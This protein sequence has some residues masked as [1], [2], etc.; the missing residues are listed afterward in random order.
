MMSTILDLAIAVSLADHASSAINSIIGN[1]H[2]MENASRDAQAQME[3]FKT[4]GW[5]GATVG[6]IG[7]AGVVG[8]TKLADKAGEVQMQLIQLGSVYGLN[9]DDSQLKAIEQQAQELSQKTLFSKKQ[10]IGIDLELAHA[11][12]TKEAMQK[13]LPEATYLAEVEVGMGKSSSPEQTA[14]NFARMVDDAG[15]SNKMD[16]MEKFADSI[17]RVINVTHAS[18]ESIGETFKY[19]MPVVKNLG[20]TEQDTL[21]A[22]AMAA[23]SG[24]E[25]SMAGTHIKDF[26]ERI[27]PFKYIGTSGGNRQLEAMAD[28]G[29][30]SGIHGHVNKS[31]KMEITGIDSAALLKD[32]DHLKSYADM[33]DIL[34]KK[35]EEF[36]KKGSTTN[37][38]SQMPAEDLKKMQAYAKAQ[39]GSELTG[40]DLQWAALMNHVFGEQGQDFAVISSHKEMFDRLQ[41]QME[42]QKSLH[43]QIEVIRNSWNGQ[44]HIL[45]SN[46][47]TIGLQIGKPVMELLTPAL[48]M[49]ANAVGDLVAWFDKYPSLTKFMA[50][51]ALG[52]SVFFAVGGAILLGASALGAL[53]LAMDVAGISLGTVI[54]TSAGVLIAGAALVGIAYLIYKNWDTLK[55]LWDEYGWVVKSVATILLV[56]YTPAILVASAQLA[57][58]AMVTGFTIIKTLALNAAAGMGA[59]FMGAYRRV[60]LAVGAAQWIYSIA[61]GA[62]TAST[63]LQYLAVFALAPLMAT[64]RLAVMAWTGA[65]WLL[66]VALDANPIGAVILIITAL[67]GVVYLAIKYFDDW[68]EALKTFSTNLPGWAVVVLDAFLPIIGIPLTLIKYWDTAINKIKGFLGIKTDKKTDPPKPPSTPVKVPATLDISTFSKQLQNLP[69]MLGGKNGEGIKIPTQLSNLNPADMQ[70]QVASVNQQLSAGGKGGVK[71]PT[72]LNLDDINK[73]SA[74]LQQQM[75]LTGKN[76]GSELAKGLSSSDPLIVQ[77]LTN[78]NQSFKTNLP[79]PNEMNQFGRNLGQSLADGMSSKEEQVRQASQKLAAAIHANLGVQSPTKEGPLR[80]NHLWGGNLSKSIAA[81]MLGNLSLIQ[82]ASR[83]VANVMDLNPANRNSQTSITLRPV[84][85]MG[86]GVVIQGPLIGEVNQQPGENGEAF[87]ERLFQKLERRLGMKAQ[88]ANLT[89][90][91]FGTQR[92][93]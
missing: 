86:G 51:V 79:Q 47:E 35:H 70:K 28:A 93:W 88:K 25:G 87:A 84:H 48:R 75:N 52:I 61:T 45:E 17:N 54:A 82:S 76:S 83:T 38:V 22:T 3:K 71:I 7:T 64:I 33:I 32:R 21:L 80:T 59:F 62:A 14:Y 66:N 19:A 49:A 24:V 55:N 8:L 10:V 6:A 81:G 27:N 2:L 23:R 44:M 56:A 18:S 89:I 4:M 50:E 58:L 39:T 40:G 37:W 68:W 65:Q 13:V 30:I 20:W 78:I 31:G 41:K 77:K 12:I 57:Q 63:W 72:N 42:I 9:I 91:Q 29:L 5:I 74:T 16:R 85:A 69:G 90:G 60:M 11:G 73:Q 43:D 46:F 36:L 34:S 15:I 1:F 92:G 26:A 53:N 67:L